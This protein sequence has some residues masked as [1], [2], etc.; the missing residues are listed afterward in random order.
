VDWDH[1]LGDQP[2][3]GVIGDCLGQLV[4]KRLPIARMANGAHPDPESLENAPDVSLQLL[5]HASQPLPC[6]KERPDPVRIL[7]ANMHLDEPSGS[8]EMR[9]PLGVGTVGFV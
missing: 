8:R 1:S 3:H 7:A 4:P 2:E 6:T 5:A 9:Q